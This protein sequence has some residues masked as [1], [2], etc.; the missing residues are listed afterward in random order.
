VHNIVKHCATEKHPPDK[1]TLHHAY[2]LFTVNLRKLRR[3]AP[4]S[5]ICMH[6]SP[7]SPHD[8]RL[9][10][11]QYNYREHD[12]IGEPYFDTDF[13]R[14]AYLTDTGRRWDGQDVSVRDK[15]GDEE[16]EG[17]EG[18][19]RTKRTKGTRRTK[20]TKGTR[21]TKRTKGTKRGGDE[22][23]RGRGYEGKSEIRKLHAPC[24]TPC[25]STNDL[26]SAI[27]KGSFPDQ[28]MLTLHPQRWE[29][30]WWPWM[31]ELIGQSIK[32]PLKKLLV[33]STSY[34]DPS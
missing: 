19:R 29:D 34:P 17:T 10:W 33:R 15:I 18:T 16:M 9:I 27:K 28:V 11:T 32:N 31:K 5:T 26:I 7:L 24:S 30:D 6:G 3:I 21:R 8:N 1:Q 25:R 2:Q 23:T 22:G 14:V 20:R 13:S 4:V 12:I